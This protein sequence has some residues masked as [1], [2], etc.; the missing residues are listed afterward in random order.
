MRKFYLGD[1]HAFTM[2]GIEGREELAT[3]MN[4]YERNLLSADTMSIALLDANL[5]ERSFS[6]ADLER[7]TA[8]A[9]KRDDAAAAASTGQA[10]D[11]FGSD[12]MAGQRVSVDGEVRW[13]GA[14]NPQITV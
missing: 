12:G 4:A 2:L 1:Q 13:A 11:N 6:G 9:P 8:D 7:P 3:M 10:A 5:R 14:T